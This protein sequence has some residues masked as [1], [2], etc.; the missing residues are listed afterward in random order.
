MTKILPIRLTKKEFQM[1]DE[2]LA[3]ENCECENRSEWFRL[4]LYREWNKRKNLGVPKPQNF[5]TSFRATY[6]YCAAQRR[7]SRITH[8]PAAAGKAVILFRS[9]KLI[10]QRI[11][12]SKGVGGRLKSVNVLRHTDEISVRGS[13][14]KRLDKHSEKRNNK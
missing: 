1:L 8:S 3:S 12:E 10:S 5:Q 4:L 11:P 14:S 9:G 2:I 7:R 13:R 6:N